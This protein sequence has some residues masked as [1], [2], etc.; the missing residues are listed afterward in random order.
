[1]SADR[2]RRAFTLIELL[3]VIAIIGILIALLLPAVQAARESARRM[4]CSN[5]LKQIGLA[6]QNY[7]NAYRAIPISIAYDV[8][9]SNSKGWILS[10]LPQLE[11]QALFDQFR[12]YFASTI[13][14]AGCAPA[15]KT[16]V[17]TLQCPSDATVTQN[18]TNQWQ[19]VGIEVALTSYKGVMGDNRMG[20][21]ASVHGGSEPDCTLTSACDGLFWRYNYLAG[22]SFRSISDGLSKTLMVGES[23]PRYFPCSAVYFCNGDYASTYAPINYVPQPFDYNAWWNWWGFSSDHPGGAQFCLADGSVHF[24][25]EA[26]DQTLYEAISTRA[27]NESVDVP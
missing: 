24:L 20:G 14:S 8:A 4:T 23:R 3:V 7:H 2:S 25:D 5:H 22:L 10:I 18:S 17:P 11:E 13:Y 19:W 27:G 12:P 16:Q 21:S 6:I 15:M 26:I 1:M 9:G